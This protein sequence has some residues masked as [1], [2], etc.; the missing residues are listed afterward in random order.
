VDVLWHHY[1]TCDVA[2]VAGADSLQFSL[3]DLFCWQRIEQ[4]HP[5]ITTKG[6]EMQAALT[7]VSNWFDV[8]SWRL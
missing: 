8:H 1:I 5:V 4:R 6:D 3:K 7:L 2:A